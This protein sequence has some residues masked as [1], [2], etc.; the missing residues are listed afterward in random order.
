LFGNQK[1]FLKFLDHMG[2]FGWAGWLCADKEAA[3]AG[4]GGANR[5]AVRSSRLDYAVFRGA[6]HTADHVQFSERRFN[7]LARC[8]K[9]RNKDTY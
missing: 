5:F 7:G 6:V 3:G 2:R 9:E 1:L 8:A 4:K